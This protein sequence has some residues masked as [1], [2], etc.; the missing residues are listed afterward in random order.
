MFSTIISNSGLSGLTNSVKN[1]FLTMLPRERVRIGILEGRLIEVYYHR[2]GALW[3][4]LINEITRS[5]EF[6]QLP[7]NV[8]EL[9]KNN[10]RRNAV[11]REVRDYIHREVRQ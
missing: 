8:Q 11:R 5:P 3:D 10:V 4:V 1:N 2:H 6:G 7:N 9:Y